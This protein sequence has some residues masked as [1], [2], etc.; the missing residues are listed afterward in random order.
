MPKA[1][2]IIVGGG[3][4]GSS[5]AYNLLNDG[6]TGEIII[7]EKDSTYEY[8]S[9]PRSA[10]GIRQLF[11][12]EINVLISRYSIEKYLNFAE[13][14]AVFEEKPVID[15]K[16]RGYLLLGNKQNIK[17]LEKQHE[18]Q[19]RLGV[20][21]K[22][23]DKNDLLKLIPELNVEDLEG[24]LFCQEDGYLDPYSVLQGYVK[25]TKHLG[26][27]YIY[28]EVDEILH[29]AGEVT[30]VRL[31]NGDVYQAP[32]VINCAGA[33]APE[34]CEKMG[35]PI[36]VVPLKRMITV[37]QTAQSLENK[38][39]LTIDPTGVYFRHEGEA[40]ITGY[41]ED[42]EPGYDFTWSSKLFYEELW[43]VLARRVKNF[44]QVKVVRGWAGLYSHNTIDQN[45]L[46]GK[47][48]QIKG[49][50]LACGFSGHGMQ[51]APAVG[52]GLSELI[53][54]GKYVTIDLSPLSI[55]RLYTNQFVKEEAYY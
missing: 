7:F 6:F 40:I 26:G 42:V 50:Y 16:Q 27:R 17:F 45:A 38:L 19:V 28:E 32:I 39:P 3:V 4:I 30:G 25:K 36:P 41:A 53:R 13:E 43:H 23:L 9:T 8:A 15:F 48:P 12:T 49:Y 22:L 24:G 18:M 20:P 29:E 11:S 14:M 35:Y 10:G 2:V 37:F 31:T 55:E 46:I 34:L 47:H 21:S 5:I 54:L 33:W 44:E 52:K 51:Q 1:D